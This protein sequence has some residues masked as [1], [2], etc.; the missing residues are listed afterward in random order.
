MET[1]MK[2]FSNKFR[3]AVIALVLAISTPTAIGQMMYGNTFPFWNVTGP[4]TVGTTSTLTGLVTVPAGIL[5]SATNDAAT[6]GNVGEFKTTTVAA[7][8]AVAG[9]ASTV[10][11]NVTSVSLTAGDWM[12]SGT[13]N[14]ILSGM[15]TT[16]T[17]CGLGTTTATQA[18]QAGGSGIGTDPLV[19]DRLVLTTTTGAQSQV[20]P[21][22]RVTLASTT[23]IYLVSNHTYSAGSFTQYGTIKAWRVR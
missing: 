19:I 16:I 7:G 12:V 13:C 18:S 6:A 9:G 22:T 3:L 1:F 15:T 14:Y 2:L 8:S 11:A 20:V 23:T 21:P 4:L 10:S 5:G 17:S